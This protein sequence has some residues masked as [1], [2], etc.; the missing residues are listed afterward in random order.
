MLFNVTRLQ[1]LPPGRAREKA[2]AQ[3][4]AQQPIGTG[5]YKFVEWKRD[6]QLVLEA[7]PALLARRRRPK[8]LVFR[9]I[10]DAQ[11]PSRRAPE[12]RRRHHRQRRRAPQLDMLGRGETQ[13]VPVKGGSDHHLPVRR[14]PAPFDN[15]KVREA[16][17][18]AVE[19]GR[20]RR[21]TCSATAASC[22]PAR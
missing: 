13:V 11:H 15:R 12:R 16:A 6:Q 21:R 7:N 10:R 4:F 18:L 22:S 3:G 17:N 14:Q 2:G 19:Q 20:H 1:I 9:A 8:R 5:P